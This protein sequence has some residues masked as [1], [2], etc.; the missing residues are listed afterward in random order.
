MPKV[1]YGVTAWGLVA[2]GSGTYKAPEWHAWNLKSWTI[3]RTAIVFAASSLF[4][5]MGRASRVVRV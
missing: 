1:V 3:K 4:R 5:E 2:K